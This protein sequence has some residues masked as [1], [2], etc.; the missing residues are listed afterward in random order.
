MA[1]IDRDLIFTRLPPDEGVVTPIAR[2]DEEP[3]PSIAAQLDKLQSALPGWA[4]GKV[5]DPVQRV[6]NLLYVAA[7]PDV[8]QMTDLERFIPLIV[9]DY[10][11]AEIPRDDLIKILYWIALHPFDGDDKAVDEL[12]PLGLNNGPADMDTTRDRLSVYA[13]KLLGRISGKIKIE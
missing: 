3:D 1:D 12:R 10:I 9:Y 2:L 6:R 5:Q 7:V 13:V 8:F 11:Q 4:P